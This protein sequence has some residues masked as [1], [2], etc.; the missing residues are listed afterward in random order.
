MEHWFGSVVVV[1][2]SALLVHV[3]ESDSYVRADIDLDDC[4]LFRGS[5]IRDEA[6]PLYNTSNCSFIEKEFD[7]QANGRPDTL[8]LKY[9]WK[10]DGCHLPKFDGES[11]LRKLKGR[12]ILFVGDSLS[13]NQWQSFTCMLHAAVRQSNYTINRNGFVSVFTF[14]EYNVSVILSR[15]GFLV[16]VVKERVGRVLKL[17]SIQNGNAWKGYDILIFNTWH[18]WLHKASKQPWDYIEEGGKMVKDMD[19]LIAFKKGITTWANWVDSNINSAITQVFFQGISPTHY[20]GEEWNE[21][22]STTCAE[23][24]EPVSGSSYPGGSPPAVAV[25]KEVLR[26]M[27]TPVGLLDV[28]TLSQLRRDGHPSIYG[29]GGGRGNDCSHWCL[30][31][32]PDTWNELLFALI[33]SQ[34]TNKI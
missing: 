13:L 28:T 2:I 12:K 7:C 33:G 29:F 21:L 19:R 1:L 25:V 8:Y 16:D 30:P 34:V 17:D 20:N 9:K 26:K 15:N 5:W 27:R 31:G 14:S 11:M 22:E 24:T 6:Y 18:W 4:D 32:V 10:P 23:Q 3:H